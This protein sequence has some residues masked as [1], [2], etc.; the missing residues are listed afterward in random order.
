VRPGKHGYEIVQRPDRSMF[1]RMRLSPA[2][3][4]KHVRLEALGELGYRVISTRGSGMV[5]HPDDDPDEPRAFWSIAAATAHEGI[6]VDEVD[7]AGR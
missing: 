3:E 7:E 1:A 2:G 6:D 4:R 5:I